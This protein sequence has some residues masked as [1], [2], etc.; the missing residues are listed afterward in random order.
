MLI[1]PEGGS[2]ASVVKEF[3]ID[4][5]VDSVVFS[6]ERINCPAGRILIPV[7]VVRDCPSLQKQPKAFSGKV[8]LGHHKQSGPSDTC[9]CRNA[10]IEK[11]SQDTRLVPADGKLD[12]FHEKLDI[13]IKPG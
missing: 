5:F 13:F 3:P 7:I 10:I 1:E 9:I 8:G 4:F 6:F 2:L 11:I 12:Q